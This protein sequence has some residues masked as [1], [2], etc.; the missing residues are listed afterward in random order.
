LGPPIDTFAMVPPVGLAELH[1]DPPDPMPYASSH[2]LT[3]ELPAGAIDDFVAMSGPGSGSPLASVELRHLGG[4]LGRSRPGH[5]AVSTL[6]GPC[7]SFAVGI[8][9]AAGARDVVQP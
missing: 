1:M 7:A 4:A 9:A 8:A 3:D 2:L 6:P 5:G